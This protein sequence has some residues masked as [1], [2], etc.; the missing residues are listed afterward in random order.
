MNLKLQAGY[1]VA[2]RG[3][4]TWRVFF[5]VCNWAFGD[6]SCKAWNQGT[7]LSFSAPKQRAFVNEGAEEEDHDE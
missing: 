7:P 3:S 6:A 5:H 4:S 2:L 1:E